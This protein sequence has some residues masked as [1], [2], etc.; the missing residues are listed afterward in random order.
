[1]E[2]L[3]KKEETRKRQINKEKIKSRDRLEGW[4][5]EGDIYLEEE[6]SDTCPHHKFPVA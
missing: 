3:T 4:N 1:M 2:L 5:I 6:V